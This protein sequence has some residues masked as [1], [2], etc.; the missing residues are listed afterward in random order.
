VL[1]IISCNAVKKVKDDEHLLIENKILVNEEEVQKRNIYDQLYQ[2]PNVKLPLLGIPLKLHIY[3]AANPN[4]D[5]TFYNW[6]RKK[7]KR[8]KRLINWL[9]K[10]QLEKFG[11]SIVGFN[12]FLEETG[13][14]PVILSKDKTERSATRLKAWYWNHGWFNAETGYEITKFNNKRAKV[15]YTVKP[16]TPYLVDSISERIASPQADS[17][18]QRYK[19][20]SLVKK[21][22]QFET[23][24]FD[25]ERGRIV[26]LFRNNG[27]YHFEQEYISFDADTINTN[28]KVNI[29]LVIAD[30]EISKQDTS[31]TVP[32]RAHYISDVN[33]FTDYKFENQDQPI[34]D[35][36]S[37]KG[38]TLYSFEDMR[39]KPEA[40]ADAV[41]IKKGD[42]YRDLDRSL[43]Y[44]RMNEIGIF[45]Y[46]DIQY[47]SDPR[48]STG[49]K[50]ISNIF[51]T[52]KPKFGVDFN[53][54]VSRSNIQDF[55]I[56]FGGSLL[57]RNIFRGAE[58]LE[59]GGRGSIGS[60][61]DAA[62]SEDRF[63][64][65]SEIGAD[66][67]LTFPKIAFPINTD[68]LI[69][70]FMSPFTTLSAGVST[71]QNIGLDKQNVTGKLNYRWYP[72]KELTHRL[73]LLDLQYVRNLNSG[74]YFNVYRN[75]FDRLNDIAQNNIDQVNP[76]YFS[77]DEDPID[78]N[79]PN[80]K[81]PE[82]TQAFIRDFNNNQ[83]SLN[84]EENRIAQNIIERSTR[85]TQDN[86]ILA[87][88]FSY[89]KNTRES[90]Y[91]LQFSQFRLKLEAAGNTLSLL[92]PLLNFNQRSDNNYELFGV[93]FS[94][95]AKLET[96]FIKHWDLGQKNVFAIRAL[97][98]IA[99]PYGNSNSIPFA[100]SFFAGGANDNRGWQAYDL[101][102]GSTG[103]IN[104]FNEANMKITLNAEYRFNLFG[105]LNSAVFVDVGNIWNVLDNVEDEPSK[106]SSIS[107]LQELAVSSGL[108][109]R[110][111]LSFFVIRFDV[112][113]KTY[114]PAFN[115]QEWFQ[116]YNF[117]NAVYNV[118]IN[119]PF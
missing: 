42:V 10:K 53:F 40:I 97:G 59:I 21:G 44:K 8:E 72:N 9:S 46:P 111:D 31:Y 56:G 93:Q 117:A 87:S 96:D 99:I 102:P 11:Q 24:K 39:Y 49:T 37:Y 30:R 64:N 114:N 89:I 6:L 85:L 17:V 20:E 48:D 113:F 90:I 29:D 23:D 92:S 110:Y 15:D 32:Y 75:S 38:Y 119:Y 26:S 18:Y 1:L 5:T 80:L 12:E 70:K 61:K 3:N 7:P 86:L 108:G 98:G 71:Q 109:L 36:A 76:A 19:E 101:G 83:F 58:T 77:E 67:N 68:K 79:L 105:Q 95:Y 13:E 94:Q 4:P 55:G 81:I 16:N 107:D 60:S 88:S 66:A 54:D 100:R 116:D 91:D 106:F 82:G 112:G 63:F 50:L 51:L 35:S 34:I 25:A 74:N 104:E 2:K 103:G 45:K 33:I 69:P 22:E 57:I 47:M 118:G 62:E 78:N 84:A 115:K 73:D 43:T 28:H 41:F 27:F 14:G 52:P 65:I